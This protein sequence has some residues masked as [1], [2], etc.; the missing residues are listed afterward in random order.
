[1]PTSLISLGKISFL[2]AI[3]FTG[4]VSMA[5]KMIPREAEVNLPGDLLKRKGYQLP[6]IIPLPS[7]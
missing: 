4:N 2:L 3:S 6:L 1:M 5:L 7:L